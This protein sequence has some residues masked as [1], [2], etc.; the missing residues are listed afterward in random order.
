MTP[1]Q[2]VDR[3]RVAGLHARLMDR[4]DIIGGSHVDRSGPCNVVMN[5]FLLERQQGGSYRVCTEKDTVGESLPLDEAVGLILKLIPP[6][7]DIP[8]P[9]PRPGPQEY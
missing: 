2:A 6:G 7:E 3:L 4:G 8:A 1:E 5:D 9:P